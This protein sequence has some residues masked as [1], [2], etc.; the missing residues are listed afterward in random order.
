MNCYKQSLYVGII[1]VVANVLMLCALFFAMFM[2]SHSPMSSL[3][4]FCMYF[5]GITIPVWVLAFFCIRKV[6]V[7]FRADDMSVVDLPRL[8][9]CLVRWQI[10]DN[11]A[12][13]GAAT[14]AR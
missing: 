12:P 10:R 1:R 4:T 9:R 3:A 6:R 2:A 8:G 5:F 7:H 13:F 14:I 11:A